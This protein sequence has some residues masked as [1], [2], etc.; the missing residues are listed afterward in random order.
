MTTI[1]VKCGTCRFLR[2]REDGKPFY[3]SHAYKCQWVPPEILWPA[4][5]ATHSTVRGLLYS[6]GTYMQPGDGNACPCWIA[7]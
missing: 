7:K 4:S 3:H 1:K 5:V 6:P 2:P